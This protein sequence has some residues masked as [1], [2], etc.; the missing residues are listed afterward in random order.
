MPKDATIVVAEKRIIAPAG[1]IERLLSAERGQLMALELEHAVFPMP[2]TLPGHSEA[3][4]QVYASRR[5]VSGVLAALS[6][7]EGYRTFQI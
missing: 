2:T 7:M 4:I 3:Q 5:E 6:D 1:S